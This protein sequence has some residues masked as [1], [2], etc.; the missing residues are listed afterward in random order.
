MFPEWETAF[1][2]FIY[3]FIFFVSV[4]HSIAS[5]QQFESPLSGHIVDPL[6]LA[7]LSYETMC[8]LGKVQ[9]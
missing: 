1:L 5:S 3:L 6:S 9:D 7:M 2:L 8:L 4:L